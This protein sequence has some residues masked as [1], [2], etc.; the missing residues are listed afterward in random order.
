MFYKS[1]PKSYIMTPRRRQLFR[2]LTRG[3]RNAFAKKCL[4]DHLVKQHI[5]KAMGTSLRHEIAKLCSDN[6]CFILCK[7]ENSCLKEFS[8][9]QLLDEAKMLAPTL[10][11]LLYSCT[12]TRKLRTNQNAVIGA[13]IGIMCKNRRPTSSLFQ[14]LVYLILYSGHT[15]KRVSN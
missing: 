1:E 2:P 8:W 12:K 7:R 13:L 5:V 9:E 14:Q 4:K 10:I 11:Q 15:S 3:S 6:A